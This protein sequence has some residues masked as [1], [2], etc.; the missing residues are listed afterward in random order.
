M[1]NIRPVLLA[2]SLVPLLPTL[3]DGRERTFATP[4][5][6]GVRGDVAAV[7]AAHFDFD[8]HPDLAVAASGMPAVPLRAFARDANGDGR[9]DVIV[10]GASFIATGF[11]HGAGHALEPYSMTM[12]DF[13]GDGRADLAAGEG[14]YARSEATPIAHQLSPTTAQPRRRAARH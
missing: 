13:D 14:R 1:Y 4:V 7:V 9:T 2:I 5:A 3:A 6:Y 11:T 8:G 12:A 10:A